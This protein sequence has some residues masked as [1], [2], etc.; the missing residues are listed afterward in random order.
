M[1]TSSL[2]GRESRDRKRF[3]ASGCLEPTKI[4]STNCGG[5]QKRLRDYDGRTWAVRAACRG[6]APEGVEQRA[7]PPALSLLYSNFQR[8][9]NMIYT[10]G[11]TSFQSV[12]ID[13]ALTDTD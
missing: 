6:S 7:Q 13:K 11:Q 9:S 5:R 2:P 12:L 4:A 3:G 8:C 1:A 10:V